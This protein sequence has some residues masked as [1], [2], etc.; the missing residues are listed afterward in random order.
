MQQQVKLTAR[1]YE[2][3]NPACAG[4][5]VSI[6]VVGV[7]MIEW[8]G[9]KNGYTGDGKNNSDTLDIIGGSVRVF[10]ENKEIGKTVKPK[11]KVHLK[12]TLST[13]P[14]VA[15]PIFLKTFD[16]DDPE[17]DI[18]F[19]DP[20]D[21]GTDGADGNYAGTPPGKPVI[22]YTKDEDN[23]GKAIIEGGLA[24]AGAK[25]GKI[26]GSGVGLIPGSVDTYKKNGVTTKEVTLDFWVAQFCGDN[27][28]VGVSNDPEFIKN[29]RNRDKLDGQKI[30]HSCLSPASSDSCK[31]I[32]ISLR[33]PVLTVWRTLHI[34]YDLMKNPD[35]EDNFIFTG[36]F[37]NFESSSLAISSAIKL[38]GLR[39][40]SA[41]IGLYKFPD[42]PL[43]DLSPYPGRFERGGVRICSNK[44][45]IIEPIAASAPV[46]ST[47]KPF[48]SANNDDEVVFSQIVD[49]SLGDTLT[50][51]LRKVGNSDFSFKIK[52]INKTA[53]YPPEFEVELATPDSIIFMY[54]NSNV[55]IGGGPFTTDNRVHI[56]ND[57][58]LEVRA[59]VS[60]KSN[61]HI[62]VE[63][64]DDD[65]IPLNA[66]SSIIK[67]ITMIAI[68]SIY[69]KIYINVVN[70]GGGNLSNSSDSLIFTRNLGRKSDYAPGGNDEFGGPLSYINYRD[71][72]S[73]FQTNK[74]S[75][76]N[77]WICQILGSWQGLSGED[78]DCDREASSR[79]V[80]YSITRDSFLSKGANQAILFHEPA[81]E[82]D[83]IKCRNI[84][85]TSPHE[86]GH[87]F[88]LGHGDDTTIG[89]LNPVFMVPSLS[90]MGIMVDGKFMTCTTGN[91]FIPYHQNIIRIRVKSPGN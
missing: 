12:I 88:G 21:G 11:T 82:G 53:T 36:T 48:L 66:P 85:L 67:R 1:A 47:P 58:T 20:N 8:I 41:K 45:P 27:Y 22:N 13:V 29:T 81:R 52:E 6:T 62:P 35:W 18:T 5:F 46:S 3:V 63:V 37:D 73:K 91:N 7:D 39:P 64:R 25:Q 49:L 26:S 31:E 54:E 65:A 44:I 33:S 19:I 23:R 43:K 74:Y 57:N 69:G 51:I 60:N 90:D 78:R 59:T 70:D 50:G 10:P 9:V 16:I 68:D 83:G 87:C 56:I 84:E 89:V 79:G 14:P 2:D 24:T 76:D 4:N 17:T 86:L 42:K 32:D 72:S 15:Q 71:E 28:R 38:M 61:L 80:C 77:Y 75:N 55:S 34:E 40:D 30:M